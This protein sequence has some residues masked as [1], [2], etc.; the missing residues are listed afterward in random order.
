MKTVAEQIGIPALLEGAAEEC[1][2]LAKVCLKLARKFRGENP[3][4]MTLEEI[5]NNLNEEIADVSLCIDELHVANIIDGQK[6]EE[7]YTA[8]EKRWHERLKEVEKEAE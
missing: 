8:K 3:T 6:I 2:E 4:P 1:A 7:I 5:L